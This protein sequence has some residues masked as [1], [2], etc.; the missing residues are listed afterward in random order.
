MN[1]IKESRLCQI[2]PDLGAYWTHLLQQLYVYRIR[3]CQSAE[4]PEC[5][6]VN[7]DVE[8]GTGAVPSNVDRAFDTRG[9]ATLPSLVSD[10]L[11]YNGDPSD[12][13]HRETEFHQKSGKN[14][15]QH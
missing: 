10:R 9:H 6:G 13:D 11:G 5:H 3:V 4:Y 1:Q 2:L 15:V 7:E 14:T 8:H 12:G